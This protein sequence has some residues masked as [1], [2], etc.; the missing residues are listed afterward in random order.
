MD[1]IL[2]IYWKRVWN[3][4]FVVS[5]VESKHNWD[6]IWKQI[7]YRLTGIQEGKNV[8]DS[9]INNRFKILS[10]GCNSWVNILIWPVTNFHAASIGMM[11]RIKSALT[12]LEKSGLSFNMLSNQATGITQVHSRYFNFLI[13]FDEILSFVARYQ[14]FLSLDLRSFGNLKEKGTYI[15]FLFWNKKW[16]QHSCK[17]IPGF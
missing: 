2:P 9:K 6:M 5:H 12:K 16:W 1:I 14:K 3:V 17:N 7:V 13:L 11:A 4:Q 8:S 15:K 10:R